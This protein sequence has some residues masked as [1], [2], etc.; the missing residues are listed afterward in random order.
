MDGGQLLGL[1][2]ANVSLYIMCMYVDMWEDVQMLFLGRV[3]AEMV[4]HSYVQVGY[5]CIIRS[6]RVCNV[7]NKIRV[8]V[9]RSSSWP[10]VVSRK[11][12][13][14]VMK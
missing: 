14:L 8:H 13:N 6:Y 5:R 4:K 1:Q 7:N 3:I 2:C 10:E 9:G 11:G 12:P